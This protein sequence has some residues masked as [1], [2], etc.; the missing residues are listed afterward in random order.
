MNHDANNC[1]K[2]SDNSQNMYGNRSKQ[3]GAPGH[4][5]DATRPHK[6][7]LFYLPCAFKNNLSLFS[8]VSVEGKKLPMFIDRLWVHE[9]CLRG[10]AIHKANCIQNI[11]FV[12]FHYHSVHNHFVHDKVSFFNVEHNLLEMFYKLTC[13]SFRRNDITNIKIL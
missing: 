4:K 10:L 8:P 13:N 6:L 11:F 3:P 7:I 9:I 12:A 1:S 5:N 2:S